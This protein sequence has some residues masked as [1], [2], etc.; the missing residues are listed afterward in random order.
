MTDF[1]VPNIHEIIRYL[2][3]H[4]NADAKINNPIIEFGKAIAIGKYTRLTKFSYNIAVSTTDKLN[5]EYFDNTD[6]IST[7]KLIS[8]LFWRCISGKNFVND[9]TNLMKNEIKQR[10]L[11]NGYDQFTHINNDRLQIKQNESDC[12]NT[13]NTQ[14][15]SEYKYDN[16]LSPKEIF[17]IIDKNVVHQDSAKRAAAMLLHNHMKG[18][19]SNMVMIGPTGCGKTEIW[20]TLSTIYPFIEMVN[21]PQLTIEGSKGGYKLSSIF[22]EYID[23]PDI[24]NHLILVVDE[25]DKMLEPIISAQGCDWS[26][27]LQNEFL[28]IMDHESNTKVTMMA[29]NRS[30]KS[31]T[32]DC[33][34]ITIVLCG[35]FENMVKN[36]CNNNSSGIGFLSEHITTDDLH[37]QA[38]YTEQDLIDYGHMRIEMAARINRITILKETTTNDFFDILNHKTASPIKKLEKDFNIKIQISNKAKRM[39]AE[40]AYETKLGCRIMKSTMVKVIDELIFDEPDKSKY[41]LTQ[42]IIELLNKKLSK[43]R[44]GE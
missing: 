35:S 19:G 44:K 43:Y 2:I 30:N 37:N 24:A 21:G 13:K 1:I 9:F 23:K 26:K 27:A 6:K 17:D 15:Q 8:N 11:N 18:I 22:S 20:R 25:A 29:D 10:I 34:G 31:I 38:E 12:K 41:N 16:Q 5:I 40:Y 36:K 14:H 39:L 28:K 42:P 4:K 33:K 32:L 7:D 3:N